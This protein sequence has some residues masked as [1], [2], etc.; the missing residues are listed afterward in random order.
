[1]GH[2]ERRSFV[3]D[4]VQ[5]FLIKFRKR[6]DDI[7]YKDKGKQK[8][9]NREAAKR[10]RHTREKSVIPTSEGTV[11]PKKSSHLGVIPKKLVGRNSFGYATKRVPRAAWLRDD[12]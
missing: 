11:I 2:R 1:M 9:A 7:M 6:I 5:N 10:Y 4:L 3:V 12:S 8:E